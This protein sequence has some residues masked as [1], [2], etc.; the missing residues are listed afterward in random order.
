MS[1][2]FLRNNPEIAVRSAGDMLRQGFYED[3]VREYA[4]LLLSA[5]DAR[6]CYEF[7][8]TL[9]RRRYRKSRQSSDSLELFFCNY[10]STKKIEEIVQGISE[11][12]TLIGLRP[13]REVESDRIPDMRIPFTA[14]A[15]LCAKIFEAVLQNPCDILSVADT[16]YSTVI[17]ALFYRYIWGAEI[18]S[19]DVGTS[20]SSIDWQKRWAKIPRQK[21]GAADFSSVHHE[22]WNQVLE[23]FPIADAADRW[24]GG[25][26]TVEGP[27]LALFQLLGGWHELAL[28]QE[29]KHILQI[30]EVYIRNFILYIAGVVVHPDYPGLPVQLEVLM[31]NKV[32]AT[33]IARTPDKQN[34]LSPNEV[35]LCFEFSTPYSELAMRTP[36][37]LR[38]FGE[39]KSIEQQV[40]INRMATQ[41][42]AAPAL[43]PSIIIPPDANVIGCV[44]EYATDYIRGWALCLSFPDAA[45]ELIMYCD[46]RPFSYTKTSIY[47]EGIRRLHGGSGYY[48]FSFDVPSNL[49]VGAAVDV[50]IRT[51]SGSSKLMNNKSRISTL[52]GITEPGLLD[53]PRRYALNSN[54]SRSKRISIIIL[55]R[56]GADLLRNMF[57]SCAPEDLSE[58]TEW[59]IVDHDSNDESDAVCTDFSLQGANVCF[60]QRRGN[61]SFSESN[62]F[63]VR[64]ATGDVILFANNDLIFRE[65]FGQR[66]RDYMSDPAIGVVG[67]RLLDHVDAPAPEI[68][69]H[70]GVFFNK[71]LNADDWVRPYEA[72]SCQETNGQSPST[73]AICVTG[74]FLAMH[75]SDFEAVG[76][77][78]EA[79]S[80]GLEDVDICLKI[81]ELL[82]KEVICA[83]DI[84]VVH[85][86]GFS[87]RQ[88]KHA[89]IRRRRNNE[90]FNRRWGNWLRMRIRESMLSDPAVIT[91]SR[92]VIGFICADIGYQTSAAEYFTAL[93]L[94][95]AIQDIIPCHVRYIPEKDW[96]DLAGI[97]VLIVMADC[98]DLTKIVTASPWLTTVNWMR[99]E[100]GNWA[101]H[102]A[103]PAYDFLLAS[104]GTAAQYIEDYVARP[105]G[106]LPNAA[107]REV[108]QDKPAIDGRLRSDYS[109]VGNR[110][111]LPREIEFQLD[112]VSIDGVG[113][114]FGSNWNGTRLESISM[115]PIPYAQVPEVYA[116]TKILLDDS[117]ISA[118][119][120]GSCNSRVFDAMAAGCLLMTNNSIGAQEVF[121]DLVPTFDS[122]DNLTAQI[123]QWLGDE[124]MRAVSVQQMQKIVREE[125]NYSV[126]ARALLDWMSKT[127]GNIRISIKCA[128]KYSN[129]C[130]WGDFHYAESLA[131][132]L[133]K[134]GHI[135][136]VDCREAWNSGITNS[137]NVVVVLRGLDAYKPRPHQCNIMWLISHPHA[138]SVAEMAEFDHVFVASQIHANMLSKD[139]GL[140][141]SFLPQCTDTARFYVSNAHLG[142]KAE[143]K[144]YV[145][146]SRG[147]FRDP[148]RWAIQ[149]ELPMDIY[150][151]NWESF[152][153]DSRYRGKLVPNEILSELYGSSGLVICD[154][155][156]D[157]RRLGY[158]SNRLFDVLA[159]GGRLVIDRVAGLLDLVP[160]RFITIYDTEQDFVSILKD[161]TPI[162]YDLRVEAGQWV[163]EHHSFD[164]R[165]RE[166]S[167]RIHLCLSPAHRGIVYQC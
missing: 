140:P 102:S 27:Y 131:T 71:T 55:N 112:P 60:L 85:H 72:R 47:R 122:R 103:T 115:G 38:I 138:V 80:Y 117:N 57:A 43:I 69:Q 65:S 5:P 146:N 127:G 99:H 125:H 161:K 68:I 42:S 54:P 104:S 109:F 143:R 14:S 50:E 88:D 150:G 113:K 31:G 163:A 77:F 74:A 59:I 48:G 118:N 9:A 45:I 64:H 73:R 107:R 135:V 126:R 91:G 121:G 52:L 167:D 101:T 160:E 25:G 123:N 16:H 157:M 8:L 156:E 137:D 81:H 93:E 158:V 142:G 2:K 155:W 61:Y 58:N 152:I 96:Y 111:G 147:I 21:N 166:I 128:A 35:G 15:D 119:N 98:F 114:V 148:V 70:L 51:I 154:H 133:R 46:G 30:N 76:G 37:S 63:G 3:A 139:F 7:N 84:T 13:E 90:V 149:H 29:T 116:S 105:V 108:C 36:L 162:N 34:L 83:N 165:A 136:R 87:R 94:G 79:Y 75:R 124:A 132:A 120:L 97:D 44:E 134:L 32:V 17:F 130:Q 67:V 62:N 159:S 39:G 28:A 89:A 12:V 110:F 11:G 144:L 82:N 106:I 1:R 6:Q 56:N 153:T 22:K 23:G 53:A 24:V 19:L 164:V 95:R 66:L 26:I 40:A 92:P 20:L 151:S 78:D 10:A 33:T 4:Q 41:S 100:F 49:F 86:R 145:A 129:R 141:S 18:R